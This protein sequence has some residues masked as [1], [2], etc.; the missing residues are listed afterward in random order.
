MPLTASAP[1][2]APWH[3]LQAL[4]RP[5]WLPAIVAS[6]G[7]TARRLP[8]LQR[9]HAALQRGELPPPDADAA[10]PQALQPMRRAVADLGLAA[11]CGGAPM[12]AD[13]VLRTMLWHL[14]R[15]VDH[16]PRLARPEAIAKA[17]ADFRAE[18]LREQGDLDRLQLLLRALGDLP[19]L[20]WDQLKGLLAHRGWADAQRIADH[21]ARLPALA[22]LIRRLG[23]ARR[24]IAPRRAPPP[25]ADV[26]PPTQG[27]RVVQ[28]RLPDMPG[29]LRG[30]RLSDRLERMLGSEAVQLAHPVLRKLWRARLAESRLLTYDTEA[31]LR[32]LRPD[33]TQAARAA[34]TPAPPQALSRGPILIC[35]D[36]S[37]S[38]RGAPEH[39]AK[40]VVLQAVRTARDEQRGCLMIAFGGPQEIM[41]RA[42]GS[43]ADSLA[44]LLDLMGQSFDGGTDVQA[45]IER[46]IQRVHEAR[47]AS[48]D[49]LIVSDG[50]FGCTPATLEALDAARDRFGLR[51]QGILIGDRETMGL[52]EVADDIHWVRG[53]RA[54]GD[55]QAGSRAALAADGRGAFS[56][57]HSKSLTALFFP[58]A[59]S[60]RAAR[61]R[62][63]AEPGR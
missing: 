63:D 29:E 42:L 6:A 57:V 40:A 4:A 37:G 28:T 31:E 2:D 59:L 45:P 60:S 48:A 55:D 26:S 3:H 14:D 11:A 38:M 52:M 16:Q 54:H 51:V 18:W 34:A 10:D 44:A 35:L 7:R 47:W 1:P 27:W 13:Q 12:L 22:E 56:P 5:L 21:L 61:H 50:E 8:D 39:I 33:P 20:R 41:E 43:D 30:I 49:L 24:D 23:R 62:P 32:D 19:N 17:V 15:I 53:W 9:W 25:P 36:T 58:N 46:A